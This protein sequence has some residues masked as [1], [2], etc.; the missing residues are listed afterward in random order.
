MFNTQ[1]RKSF[2]VKTKQVKD[3]LYMKVL[4]LLIDCHKKQEV[5]REKFEYR[6]W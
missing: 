6:M 5:R 2:L 3:A 1:V 4:Y